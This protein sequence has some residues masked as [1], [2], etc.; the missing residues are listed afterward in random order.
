MNSPTKPD[1]EAIAFLADNP[2]MVTI[3][4]LMPDM[5]G[6][7]RGKQLTHD[8]LPKLYTEGARMPGSI[9]LLDWTGRN[10]E[11]FD[12]GTSD[13]DPDFLCFPVAGTLTRI[14]V[15]QA[16]FCTGDRVHGGCRRHPAFCRPAAF[17]E[18]VHDRFT[19]MELTPV[20]AIEYEFY[21]ID[22]EAAATGRSG[23]GALRR[24]R[25][26]ASTTNV[27]SIDE[28]YD[29]ESL[30]DEIQEACKDQSIPAETFV[31]EY[32]AGQFEINLHHTD[33]ALEGVRSG[34][35]AG[36]L[37]QVCGAQA[38]HDRQLH[39]QTVC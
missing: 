34:D 38:R 24:N 11:T 12:Y 19:E 25:M 39:G 3:D 7:L 36:A 28:L 32:A 26:A 17:A 9:Y 4:M 30:L 14:D 1:S 22:Q 2:D 27:Y 37:H 23:P 18:T 20:V 15:G 5:N 8:Y 13:G 31:S 33:D 21:L 35:H 6:I 29:F 10:V 16:A